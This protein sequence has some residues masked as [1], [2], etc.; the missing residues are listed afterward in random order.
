MKKL[1]I[2]TISYIKQP[3]H[4]VELRHYNRASY[5]GRRTKTVLRWE[6]KSLMMRLVSARAELLRGEL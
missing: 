5:A 1:K 4:I 2:K 6:I 3:Q